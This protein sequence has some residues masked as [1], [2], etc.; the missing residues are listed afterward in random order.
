MQS[1]KMTRYGGADVETVQLVQRHEH[2][3]ESKLPLLRLCPRIAQPAEEHNFNGV[4][5]GLPVARFEDEGHPLRV[6]CE[7]SLFGDFPPC[8]GGRALGRPRVA[9]GEHPVAR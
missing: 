9:A 7:T 6:D 5:P 4:V 8:T 1:A 2:R 3:V